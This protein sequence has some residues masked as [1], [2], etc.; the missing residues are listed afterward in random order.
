[1]WVGVVLL[2]A[3]AC[4]PEPPN[5]R[6]NVLGSPTYSGECTIIGGTT[7]AFAPA[8]G[9][10]G[11]AFLIQTLNGPGDYDAQVN[12]VDAEGR[13]GPDARGTVHVEA[14]ERSGT[15]QTP[16]LQAISGAAVRFTG[17]WHCTSVK[18]AAPVPEPSGGPGGTPP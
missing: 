2:L 7:F 13:Y 17:R 16:D 1:M 15:I 14:S 12:D 11:P 9:D 4:L 6:D 8:R 5:Q 10:A 3:S 18:T